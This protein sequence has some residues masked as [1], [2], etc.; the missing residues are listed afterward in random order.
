MTTPEDVER[1]A[2]SYAEFRKAHPATRIFQRY[3]SE[4]RADHA[5]SHRLG[6][7]QREQVGFFFYVHPMTGNIAFDTAKQAT[8]RAYA[9]YLERQRVGDVA[10]WLERTA[11]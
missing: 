5:A 2:M 8:T 6:Y 9:I 4:Q 7:R 1:A 3:T 11:P 10:N